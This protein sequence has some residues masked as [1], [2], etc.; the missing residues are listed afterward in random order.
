MKL[1][2]SI[3]CNILP[4][5][6]QRPFQYYLAHLIQNIF[7]A[8]S[9][10]PPLP[11]PGIERL[12]IKT[13]YRTFSNIANRSC[14]FQL[15]SLSFAVKKHN[16]L[17]K[18]TT[19][20]L[21][22][23]TTHTHFYIK[24]KIVF[25]SSSSTI[26][27]ATSTTTSSS[28]TYLLHIIIIHHCHHHSHTHQL[29]HFITANYTIHNHHLRHHHSH[30]YFCQLQYFPEG[31]HPIVTRVLP[32]PRIPNSFSIITNIFTKDPIQSPTPRITIRDFRS[33]FMLP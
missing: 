11:P 4:H 16:K 33:L 8:N 20:P 18:V 22:T 31:T 9:Y 1:Y 13:L 32:Y 27:K 21:P 28:S 5:F 23:T 25:P 14:F 19:C 15:L 26:T 24:I 10:P 7:V 6:I 12:L 3:S 29:H 2:I 17:S 30:P